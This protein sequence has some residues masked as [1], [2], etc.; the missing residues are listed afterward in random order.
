MAAATQQVELDLEQ[1]RK[2]M[3]NEFASALLH[4]R[5]VSVDVLVKLAQVL[6]LQDPSVFVRKPKRSELTLLRDDELLRTFISRVHDVVCEIPRR[7]SDDV[8][9]EV[10]KAADSML[11]GLRMDVV[12]ANGDVYNSF[13][14]TPPYMIYVNQG[15]DAMRRLQELGLLVYAGVFTT[16]KPFRPRGVAQSNIRST[17]SM[18]V[19]QVLFLDVDVADSTQ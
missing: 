1:L 10:N 13:P 17:S 4:Q 11:S 5:R 8:A 7:L 9:I 18:K 15:K 6:N 16:V 2:Y 12:L 3:S 19:E 14:R